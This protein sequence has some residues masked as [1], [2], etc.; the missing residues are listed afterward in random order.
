M[1]IFVVLIIMILSTSSIGLSTQ[2]SHVPNDKPTVPSP[3]KQS[4]VLFVR[5]GT[6]VE[7]TPSIIQATNGTYFLAYES[8]NPSWHFTINLTWSPDGATWFDVGAI[9]GTGG[10]YGNRHPSLIQRQDGDLQ[11]AYLTDR[12]GT[13][14]LY[15]SIST[16]GTSWTEYGPLGVS[17]PAINPFIIQEEN[18]DFAM[19]YQRYGSAFDG[20][21]FATSTDGISWTT[22]GSRV[23]TR[24]LP[25]LMRA[26][27]GGAYLMTFQGGSSGDFEI[28]YKTSEDGLGWSSEQTLTNT[29]NSHDSFP[30]ELKNGTF[31][32]YFC[33]S[34]GGGGYELY[35]KWSPDM[36]AWSTDELID[37]GNF[38]FDTEPHAFQQSSNQT[39]L[40]AWGY[41]SSGPV[42]GYEDVDVALIWI[43]DLISY[44]IAL[45]QGWNLVS[46]PVEV[47][48]ETLAYVLDPI[49]GQWD[50]VQTYDAAGWHSTITSRPSALNDVA[51]LNNTVGFWIDCTVVQTV[52]AVQGYAPGISA[53]PLKAGWNLVGYPSF[54]ERTIADA[55]VGTGVDLPVEGYDGGSP[56]WITQLPNSYVMKPGEAYWIHVPSD[57]VWIVDW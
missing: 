45:T 37:V 8:G 53:I 16:D 4:D 38:R 30:F 46:F 1:A 15:T 26:S 51:V 32:V 41:E 17:G 50:N 12:A 42:G 48:D 14:Q 40:L 29:G 23:S 49:T 56:Y 19:S 25:R 10:S 24:S 55:L 31:M 7:H 52:L 13:F 5:D 47:E 43:E 39:T 18:G 11:L 33:T 34:L 35:R 57:T 20:S 21:Y 9:V 54:N 44:D 36:S 28:R 22:A 6:F 2:E 27:G 3:E